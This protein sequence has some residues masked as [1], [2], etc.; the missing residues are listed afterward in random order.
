M[1]VSMKIWNYVPVI[2]DLMLSHKV[3]NALML[4]SGGL[5]HFSGL[6]GIDHTTGQITVGTFEQHADDAITCFE[7][8]LKQAGLSLDNVVKVTCYMKE[9]TADFVTWNE[10]FKRR[11]KKPYPCRISLGAPL[12]A[13]V[14]EMDMLATRESRLDA[15]KV[16]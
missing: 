6:T 15:E 5:I 16:S 9:P 1:E 7:V 8:L 3:E 11:F 14:L 12:V 2:G 4:E 13:G 10:V